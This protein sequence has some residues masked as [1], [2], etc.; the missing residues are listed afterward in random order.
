[1]CL[2][3]KIFNRYELKGLLFLYVYFDMSI[4][5]QINQVGASEIKGKYIAV[6]ETF[7]E[8]ANT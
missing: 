6:N 5:S 8:N 1:M 4:Y 7:L 3:L 2:K